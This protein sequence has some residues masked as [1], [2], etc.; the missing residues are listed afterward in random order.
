MNKRKTEAWEELTRDINAV[1]QE[2]GTIQEVKDKW[3]NLY[4]KEGVFFD[5]KRTVKKL[6]VDHHQS[7][8]HSQANK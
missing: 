3:K 7:H 1:G 2:N 6:V 8:P 5:L 4:C